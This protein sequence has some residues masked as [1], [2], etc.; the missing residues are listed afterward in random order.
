MPAIF[1]FSKYKV[2]DKIPF[3]M[4]LDNEIFNMY[5][6]YLGKETVKTRYGKFKPLNSSLFLSKGHI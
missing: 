1:D 2:N 3:S 4:F 6:R 5:I